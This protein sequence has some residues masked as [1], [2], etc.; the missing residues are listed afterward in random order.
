MW[1]AK[2]TLKLKVSYSFQPRIETSIQKQTPR[3]RTPDP[4]DD[5]V[6]TNGSVANKQ[7]MDGAVITM[8]LCGSVVCPLV[9]R[10]MS[11]VLG[12]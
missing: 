2:Q 12:S 1:A 8:I 4:W 3:E 11:M 10:R 7:L 6:M 5:F 9:E